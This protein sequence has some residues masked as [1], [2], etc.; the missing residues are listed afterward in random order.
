VAAMIPLHMV[1][2]FVA[3]LCVPVGYLMHF[4]VGA[5]SPSPTVAAQAARGGQ[6]WPPP[7]THLPSSIF[8]ISPS[9]PTRGS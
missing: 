7:A 1:F 2:Y 5:P 9:D 4:L 3:G 8:S 6:I